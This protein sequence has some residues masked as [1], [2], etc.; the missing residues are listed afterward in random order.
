[1]VDRAGVRQ[2][3]EGVGFIHLL[4]VCLQESSCYNAPKHDELGFG[5]VIADAES[6]REDSMDSRMVLSRFGDA[7]ITAGGS[8]RPH[9]TKKVLTHS[10][11]LV[12]FFLVAA[13]LKF[14]R[15]CSVV[16]ARDPK[17]VRRDT[18]GEFFRVPSG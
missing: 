9:E 10:R 8:L 12:L 18:A 17:R 7:V 14:V 3:E 16:L 15:R 5:K 6:V 2:F 11:S 1:M 13:V 4:Q